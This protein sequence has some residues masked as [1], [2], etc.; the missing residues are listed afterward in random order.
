M[1]W[2][3]FFGFPRWS[4]SSH[5]VSTGASFIAYLY[6]LTEPEFTSILGTFL[7]LDPGVKTNALAAFRADV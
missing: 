6:A 4:I 7:L 1:N 2:I 5:R 3:R